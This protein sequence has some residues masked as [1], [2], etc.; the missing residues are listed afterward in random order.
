[1]SGQVAG[2]V[3]LLKTIPGSFG[4][5]LHGC[6]VEQESTQININVPSGNV[7]LNGRKTAVK[8][9]EITLAVAKTGNTEQAT[10]T[11]KALVYALNVGTKT[12]LWTSTSG[13]VSTKAKGDGGAFNVGLVP[14]GSMPGGVPAQSG[15]ATKPVHLTGSFSS[16]TP[17]P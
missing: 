11:S 8:D 16:C 4:T 15:G 1:L 3:K 13:T 10:P 14:S 9:V 12:Y 2:T 7:L 17:W 6:Q 5:S